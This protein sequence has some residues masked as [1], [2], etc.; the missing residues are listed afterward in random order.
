MEQQILIDFVDFFVCFPEP[1]G[2]KK[3]RILWKALAKL[4]APQQGF[5]KKKAGTG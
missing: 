4:Q 2:K 1:I 5:Y 3:L